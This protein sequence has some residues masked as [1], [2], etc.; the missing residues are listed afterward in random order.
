M[1][2]L[3]PES[4][5]L[6]A[7]DL[8]DLYGTPGAYVRSGM[9]VSLDGATSSGGTSRGLQRPGDVAVLVALRAVADAVVVGAGTARSE[10]YGPVRLSERSAAWRRSHG[11]SRAVPLVVVS[12]SLDV[13]ADAPWLQQGRPVV[14]TCAASPVERREALGARA[15]V[16]VA[17]DD[18]VDLPAAAA[19]LAER[20]LQRLLCEGGPSLLG[21]VVRA[22][23]LTEVCAT[24]SPV[25]AGAGAGML[26]GALAAPVDLDLLHVLREGSTLLGHWRVV[27]DR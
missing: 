4:R 24:L 15:D 22:G 3:L 19:A 5:A 23:L 16:V 12:R 6:G 25:L 14:L 9:L 27:R 13:P 11:R 1:Q 17:G 2:L 7:D 18:V 26:G 10:A 20:G 8:L 21:D